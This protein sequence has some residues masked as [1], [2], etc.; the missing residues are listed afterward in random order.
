M[1]LLGT[2]GVQE[3]IFVHI[4]TA[5]APQ[6]RYVRGRASKVDQSSTKLQWKVGLKPGVQRM[7][8]Y[9]LLP[10]RLQGYRTEEKRS[11]E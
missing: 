3:D 7:V 8:T 10:E 1:S 11:R 6:G 9:L 2:K 4:R 5:P